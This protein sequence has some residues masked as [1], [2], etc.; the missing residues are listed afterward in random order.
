MYHCLG[1]YISMHRRRFVSLE[2][3]SAREKEK[4]FNLNIFNGAINITKTGSIPKNVHYWNSLQ[5][6]I[7]Q[8]HRAFSLTEWNVLLNSFVGYFKSDI[9]VTVYIYYCDYEYCNILINEPSLYRIY[10]ELQTK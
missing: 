3:E 8:N 9:N 1:S 10:V 5:M 7:L 2:L 6:K 4:R